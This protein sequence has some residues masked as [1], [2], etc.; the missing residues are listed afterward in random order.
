[1]AVRNALSSDPA[2]ESDVHWVGT[3]PRQVTN[4]N[5]IGGARG[6]HLSD[7]V[8]WLPDIP[9]PPTSFDNTT[10]VRFESGPGP[11][12]FDSPLGGVTLAHEL[13]HNY[14]RFHID[15]TTSALALRRRQ[16]GTRL[17][18]KIIPSTIVSWVPTA[19]PRALY[20]FD[21]I[22]QSVIPPQT[23]DLMSYA[24]ITWISAFNW[25]AIFGQ[26]PSVALAPAA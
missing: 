18:R 17:T 2:S 14:G 19:G 23:A 11:T 16:A 9:I 24:P 12:P 7:L 5:G 25:N 6:V 15:Q 26:V 4:F 3:V 22:S 1:M 21:P 10:V 13:G 20:G 8:D